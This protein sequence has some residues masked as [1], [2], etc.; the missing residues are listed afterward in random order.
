MFAVIFTLSGLICILIGL[1]FVFSS[2]LERLTGGD[3]RVVALRMEYALAFLLAASLIGSNGF[4]GAWRE[5]DRQTEVSRIASFSVFLVPL[6]VGLFVVGWRHR[7]KQPRL[8]G[9]WYFASFA[10]WATVGWAQAVMLYSFLGFIFL[11]R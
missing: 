8:A 3:E 10:A 7:R 2:L 4:V 1:V 11:V 9:S 5:P 6:A